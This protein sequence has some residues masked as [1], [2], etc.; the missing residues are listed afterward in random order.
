M[1][2]VHEWLPQRVRFATGDAA[3]GV[4]AEVERLGVKRVMVI[5]AL[6][7]A[8]LADRVVSGLPTVLRLPC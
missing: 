8:E 3:G 2:F 5:A 4:K 6:A 1:N 7:E